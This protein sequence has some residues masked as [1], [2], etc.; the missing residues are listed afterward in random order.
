M[1]AQLL[2][3]APATDRVGRYPKH[4]FL[5]QE[6]PYTAQPFCIA[7]VLPGETLQNLKMEARVVTD[8][9]KNSIIGWKKEYYFFYIKVSDLMLDAVKDMF[10]DPTNAEIAGM[11]EAA[12]IQRTYTAKGGID[13]VGK[14]LDRVVEHWFRDEGEAANAYVT[15]A[16][17]RIVQIRTNS[18][19]DSLTDKDLVPEGGAISSAID[20]GDLD[21][22]MDAYEMARSL[23]FAKATYEDFLR[24]SGISVPEKDEDKPELIGRFSDFQYP[25]N[26]IDPSTGVPSSAV[27]W[28]F[29]NG[30]R[31]PK[32][33]REPGFVLGVSVTR[34]K[35]YFSGLA[36]A[37]AGF[38]QR[39]WDWMPEYLMGMPETSLKQ[40]A[41]GT[42][43][44]GDRLTDS[45]IYWLDM[46]DELLY[47]DQFQNVKAFVANSADPATD[48]ALHLMALPSS[49]LGWK[50][51][52]EAMIDSFFVNGTSKYIR[53]D[54]YVGLS[55]KGK[56]R[57]YTRDMGLAAG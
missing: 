16:G 37:A 40:F 53:Q 10:V 15:A 7:R 54:G 11:D 22:L 51:P 28:V 29:N 42:G 47:G 1:A 6:R 20:A 8:P 46:R 41:S 14:C 57:D 27:S 31:E 21:R 38:A 39:A 55:I 23:G 36:G 32:F 13:W 26:T 35:V 25:S 48:G 33:F 3:P 12:N 5:T 24:M 52:T 56:Q 50:Y 2:A 30:L 49:A 34:P 19:L 43:P 45:D 44:I 4:P 9:V 17:D 18:F